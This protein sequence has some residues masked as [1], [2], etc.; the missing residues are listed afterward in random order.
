M[1][2][3]RLIAHHEKPDDVINWCREKSR[4]VIGWGR[5]ADLNKVNYSSPREIATAI[6][7]HYPTIE[8]AHLGGP[9]LWRFWHEMRQDDLVILS[10][11]N[12]RKAVMVVRGDYEWKPQ[13]DTT[14]F[15][16]YPHQRKAVET[17]ID[18]DELWYRVG[19]KPVKGDNMRWTLIRCSKTIDK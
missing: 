13:P 17:S 2:V 19:A 5:V 10:N 4:I 8:N 15:Q 12:K 6:L 18:A 16:H 11:G 7:H 3:W 1:N 14:V 9:S